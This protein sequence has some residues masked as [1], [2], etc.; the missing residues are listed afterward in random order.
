MVRDGRLKDMRERK[1]SNP[2]AASSA[3]GTA[4]PAGPDGPHRTRHR[5]ASIE[6]VAQQAGVSTATVSRVLNKPDLVAEE[7]SR[8]VLR[9]VEALAYRPNML[10]KGLTTQQTRVI[11]L[12]LPDIFG[13][14]YSELLRGADNEAHR[15]GYHLLVSSEARLNGSTPSNGSG[16]VFGLVDGL[17]LMVT[18]PNDALI[19]AAIRLGV[20][21][22]VLDARTESDQLDS[23][24]IDSEPGTRAAVAHL[25]QSTPPQDLRF[26]G[27][28]R[29]NFDTQSRAE[30]FRAEIVRAGASIKLGQIAFGEYSTQW[31]ERWAREQLKSGGLKGLAVLCANDEIAFGVLQTAQDAGLTVPE[32]LRLIGFDDSRLSG[33]VRPRL[34]SV[35]VPASEA[36]AAAVSAIVRRLADPTLPPERIR[37]TTRFILRESSAQG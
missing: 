21:V 11:G 15:L 3:H 24:I 27:G 33:M 12:A 26:V 5:P 34:S 25:L 23:I 6:D 30:A 22:A 14:F 17:A 4:G 18:E 37:L 7:T 20:P 35:Q 1:Q 36:G 29:T 31:G 9:A 32:D 19:N 2:D 10:A 16:Y 28:P 8:K 13:E